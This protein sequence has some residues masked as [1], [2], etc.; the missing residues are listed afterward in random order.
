MKLQNFIPIFPKTPTKKVT[1]TIKNTI[2]KLILKKQP[3]TYKTEPNLLKITKNPNLIYQTNNT[4]DN[5]PKQKSNKIYRS[6]IVK[7]YFKIG[8]SNQQHYKI[9]KIFNLYRYYHINSSQ[10]L[11]N[12]LTQ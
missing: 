10:T 8:L 7:T 9:R 6:N 11:L 4:N 1:I 12:N 2:Y 3:I 5:F